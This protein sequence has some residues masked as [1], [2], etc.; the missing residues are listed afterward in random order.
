MRN[1]LNKSLLILCAFFTLGACQDNEVV[2]DFFCGD[3]VVS[4]SDLYGATTTSNYSIVSVSVFMDCITLRISSSGCS[5]ESWNAS[6]IDSEEESFSIPPERFLRLRL[7]N[8]EAC[9]AVFEKEFTF[10]TKPIQPSGSGTV[11]L[12][13]EGWNEPITIN[14]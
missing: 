2:V 12:N 3:A 10:D 13:I 14:E 5:G 1:T 4:D 8:E 6:L 9:L 7:E 11:I